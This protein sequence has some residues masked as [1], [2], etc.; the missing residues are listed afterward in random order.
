VIEIDNA[1]EL[2]HVDEIYFTKL[3]TWMKFNLLGMN[4]INENSNLNEFAN[5]NDE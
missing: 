1:N 4:F 3:I 2:Y 5:M